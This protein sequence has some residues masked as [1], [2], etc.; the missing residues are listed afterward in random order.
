MNP[1][2]FLI[3]V[4]APFFISLNVLA[5][6]EEG[7]PLWEVGVLAAGFYT[8]EYPTSDEQHFNP[9]V[10]PYFIYR[11]EVFRIEEGSAKAVVVENDSFELDLSFSGSFNARSNDS[12]LRQGMPDLDYLFEVGPQLIKPLMSWKFKNN[13]QGKL[14]FNAK[15]RAVFST[16]LSSV[17]HQG[18]VFQ[19]EIS[20]EHANLLDN[21]LAYQIKLR[22]TW[23]SEKMNDYFY[24]VDSEYVTD[25]RA[26][27][28]AVQGYMGTSVLS[29][30]N[31]Q[32]NED[33]KLFAFAK[34]DFHS[35]TK[36]SD[37]PLFGSDQT[38]SFGVGFSWR[39]MTE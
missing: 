29:S 16:D 21:R 9:I 2:K 37:S 15:L 34:F 38:S 7:K 30:L 10:A 25:N 13:S 1:S 28:D 27:Y 36:N 23:G 8:P 31:Y 6:E 18:Y 5:Q 19:P 39:L 17:D 22:P 26:Y 14:L 33:I 3:I 24:Q 32:I 35:G 11:G 20:Y 4:I 12:S